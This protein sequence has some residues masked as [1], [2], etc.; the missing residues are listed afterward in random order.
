MNPGGR[1][2]PNSLPPTRVHSFGSF[3]RLSNGLEGRT[4][5]WGAQD[6]GRAGKSRCGAVRGRCRP[7]RLDRLSMSAAVY[8]GPARAPQTPHRVTCRPALPDRERV[9]LPGSSGAAGGRSPR[10]GFHRQ[11]LSGRRPAARQ[12]RRRDPGTRAMLRAGH[13]RVR[14]RRGRRAVSANALSRTP[15]RGMPARAWPTSPPC[16]TAAGRLEAG[17]RHHPVAGVVCSAP[18]AP[19]SESRSGG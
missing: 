16:R 11:A 10:A 19:A 3:L 15:S 13:S 12:G 5:A 9:L 7:G 14:T 6:A 2:E 18:T 4:G 1:P 8:T 17:Q